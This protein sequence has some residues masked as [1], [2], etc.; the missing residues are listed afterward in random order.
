MAEPSDAL[1]RGD[2]ELEREECDSDRRGA[3]VVPTGAGR[4]T[5]EKAALE[6]VGNVHRLMFDALTPNEVSVLTD[7]TSTVLDR[8]DSTGTSH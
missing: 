1:D 6:H 2:L 4:A 8:L 3:L 7:V 5:I